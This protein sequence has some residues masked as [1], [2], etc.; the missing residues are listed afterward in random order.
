ME[1]LRE[2]LLATQVLKTNLDG[3]DKLLTVIML[4][5]P[6]DDLLRMSTAIILGGIQPIDAGF[7]GGVHSG[8]GLF[9]LHMGPADLASYLRSQPD[10][11]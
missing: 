7:N 8:S 3:S 5:R 11:R 4:Q 6:G 2:Q 1:Y 9:V 10:F